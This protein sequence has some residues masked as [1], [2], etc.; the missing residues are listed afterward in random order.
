MIEASLT[1]VV[2]KRK[3]GRSAMEQQER[4]KT[5]LNRGREGKSLGENLQPRADKQ[6][7][8][9]CVCAN[10]YIYGVCICV[11]AVCVCVRARK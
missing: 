2:K 9:M 11:R 7:D 4:L 10:I 8:A 6:K 1:V 5:A 3:R